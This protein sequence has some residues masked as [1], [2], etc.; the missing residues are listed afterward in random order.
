MKNISLFTFLTNSR[1][2]SIATALAIIVLVILDLLATRQ[3]LYLDST[4]QTTL[5][6]LTVIIAYGIGSWILLEYTR[7][8]TRDL[9][10]KS[11]FINVMYWGITITQFLLF[12]IL[13]FVINNNAINC[14]GYFNFCTSARFET[15]LVYVISSAVASIIMGI[16]SFKFFSWYKLNKKNL[17]VLFYGLAAAT[18]AIA[19]T[20]DAYTKLVFIHVVEEGSPVGAISQSSF[21]YET[22]A[23]YHGE[24][25]YKVVN[26]QTTTLW[27]LPTSVLDLKNNLD[28]LAAL[29]YVFMWLA[30]AT[31]LRQYYK[32]ISGVDKFP[33]KF[34]IVLAVPLILYLV[35]SGLIISLPADIPYRFYIRLI[36]RAGTIGSSVLF[37]L[38]FYIATRNLRAVKV[39]DYL[40]ISAIGIIPIGIA[41]EIS[42]LQ[43]TYGVAAHSLVL[44]G[45]YLFTIGLYALAISISQDSSLRKSIRNSAL[46]VSKLADVIEGPGMEQEIERRV[47]TSAKEQEE[48]L[49]QETGVQ[50]SLTENEMKQY[51]GTVLK[52]IKILKNVDEILKKGKE[53]LQ[54]SYEFLVCSGIGGLRLVYNNYLDLYANVLDKYRK[55]EHKGIRM[56]TSITDI[57]SADLIR[58]FLEIGVPIRHVKNM[59]P[60]DFAVSDKEMIATIEK[61]EG[62]EEN[63]KS[64]LVSNEYPYIT[65]F[66][67][68]FEEL[69]K[70]GIDAKVR[71]KAIEEGVDSE[72]I[73]IIQDAVEIQN[74]GFS[75]IQT[76]IEEILVMY[77]TANAFHR[78]ERAGGIQF[79][80]EAA[81]ERG[82]K[83]RI[84]TP[85][86][87]LIVETA[88]K[89][90]M[91]QEE[92][93]QP[94]EKIGIRYIQPHFQTKVTILIVDKK[95][96]LAVEL[97]DDTKQT[98]N[99]A[100]GLAT[101]SNSQSTVLSYASIFESLWTQTELYQKLK[102]SDKVK[103][104]FV[105]IAAHELRTPIQPILGLADIL[106]SKQTDGG[107]EA[108][109]L[110]VIIRNA[111]RLRRLTEDILDVSKIESKSLGLKKELFNLSEVILNAIADF[112][113][114]IV[115]KNKDHHLKLQLVAPE[116]D[117]FMEAD[118]GRINQVI[119][120]LLS[121]AIKFTKEGSIILTVE[122]KDNNQEILVSIQDTGTG[123]HPEILPRLFTRF[124]T[125]SEV[126]TGLGL[127]ISK[128][129][130]EAHCGRIWAENNIDSSGA[131]FSFS[132]PISQ[133]IKK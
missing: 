117:I 12:T 85:E 127:F 20:E 33:V 130:V 78:Q 2:I 38:A 96:S 88:R 46:E 87:E 22:F 75:L 64:L 133:G 94:H 107:Q 83:V 59:P 123:I 105:N 41:N 32:S 77:S 6:I 98:S 36:F 92:A 69:W 109:Y 67:S 128:S 39:K 60:I 62:G 40:T 63:I 93:Q 100:I 118:K 17:M 55:H 132:L 45:S 61:T 35:G 13:L 42:A 18:L 10:S 72:G 86:D 119:S 15:T 16:M 4:S 90:M 121:N 70:N 124:A 115:K 11:L 52:E 8:V 9:R 24:I 51:L 99:E 43:Q 68:I 65:H 79:L 101:Y 58:K 54:S 31:L 95:Y 74:L 73:E 19:I 21:M 126:G 104:D 113:N 112:N 47:L 114:Q 103:D 82:V 71:I 91:V 44:L 37:G 26:P 29:P 129:I 131:T 7:R 14:N 80:T 49:I 89:L 106:R 97:K 125:K 3:I 27:V 1:K 122:K 120:N 108:E 5:F 110:D 56:V 111:K 84:L 23:K 53:I 28:Y 66:L 30:I 50:S 102:E 25:E 57:D 34:W 48:I 116:E 81:T 76:A